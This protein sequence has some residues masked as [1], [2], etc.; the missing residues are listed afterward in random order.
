MARRNVNAAEVTSPSASQTASSLIKFI[1]YDNAL[2]LLVT[3]VDGGGSCC[4]LSRKEQLFT[5]SINIF[6]DVPS[7]RVML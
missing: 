4:P 2:F 5:N 1:N 6:T 7:F 3:V